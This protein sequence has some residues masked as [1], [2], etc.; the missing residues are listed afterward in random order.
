MSALK[1][2]ARFNASPAIHAIIF[3]RI[4]TEARRLSH[5]NPKWENRL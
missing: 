1:Q 5:N 2:I 3:A 4:P